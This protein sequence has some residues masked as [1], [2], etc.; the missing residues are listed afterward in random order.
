MKPASRSTFFNS[1]IRTDGRPSLPTVAS[2]I[3]SASFGSLALAS[4]NQASNRSKGSSAIGDASRRRT[5]PGQERS[6]IAVGLRLPSRELIFLLDAPLVVD[7][8]YGV[9]AQNI[10][11]INR[12]PLGRGETT[13]VRRAPPARPAGARPDSTGTPGARADSV[14]APGAPPDSA[15]APPVTPDTA[16]VRRDTA[17][18]ALR[19]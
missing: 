9:T 15:V 11:S 6:P 3:A 2:A 1:T 12:I 10:V 5:A 8:E 18:V 7:V 16:A 4:A 17:A 19:R 13:V 14:V